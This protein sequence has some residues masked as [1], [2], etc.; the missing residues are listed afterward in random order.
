MKLNS[1]LL[2]LGAVLLVVLLITLTSGCGPL[3]YYPDNLFPQQFAY[4]GFLPRLHPGQYTEAKSEAAVDVMKVNGFDGLFPSPLGSE[5]PL[6]IYSALPSGKKCEASP[7]S[8]STGYLCLDENA[9][10]MLAT[11]GGNQTGAPSTI[12]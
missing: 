10:Q 8:T 4:E 7:Y 9:T 2:L 6:D 11:R 1:Q 12:G 5:K 3:P